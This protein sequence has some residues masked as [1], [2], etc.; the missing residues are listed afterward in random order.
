LGET[1]NKDFLFVNETTELYIGKEKT[2]TS[3]EGSGTSPLT[4][5]TWFSCNPGPK[6]I[7]SES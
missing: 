5:S 1:I 6:T 3:A 2:L 7:K 4:F